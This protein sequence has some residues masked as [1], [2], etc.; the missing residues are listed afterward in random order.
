MKPDAFLGNDPGN[1]GAICIL[2]PSIN[3]L[4][5]I[6]LKKC[7]IDI[8][9]WLNC[10]CKDYNIIDI[11]I[12]DVHS[13]YGSSSKANFGFGR[14]VQR[15]H[16]IYEMLELK[17]KLVTPKVW[18]AKVGVT[19]KGKQIKQNVKELCNHYYPQLILDPL[20]YG[21]LGGFRDGRSDSLM[22]AHYAYITHYE[23]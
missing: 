14:S 13:I 20:L 6:D 5:F 12:E 15:I 21:K 17:T 11:Y 9:Y 23:K 16:T 22:I 7:T 10:V 1:N 8:K 19:V 2:I 3:K 4:H 18:Q